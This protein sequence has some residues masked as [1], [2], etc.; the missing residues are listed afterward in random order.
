MAFN[1]FLGY[2]EVIK[3]A[4]KLKSKFEVAYQQLQDTF[5]LV[6]HPQFSVGKGIEPVKFCQYILPTLPQCYCN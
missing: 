6:D 5:D 1:Q 2:A 3:R 4:E